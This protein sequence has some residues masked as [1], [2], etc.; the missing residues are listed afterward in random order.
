[1]PRWLDLAINHRLVIGLV[2]MGCEGDWRMRLGNRSLD[3]SGTEAGSDE[4][5]CT[6]LPTT[7]SVSAFRTRLDAI[8][9]C[10]RNSKIPQTRNW[11]A[12]VKY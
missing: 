8:A 9:F 11:G 7:F 2:T 12:L 10:S 5:Y 4:E 3:L 6:F 1:M